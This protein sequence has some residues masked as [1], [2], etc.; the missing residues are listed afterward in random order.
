MASIVKL[1][2]TSDT[3]LEEMLENAREEMFNLRFQQA[4]SRLEDMSRI[5][6]VRREIAQIETVLNLRR[7]AVAAAL[8][9]PSV[10]EALDGKEW[11]ADARF[12][13][14]D[15]IWKVAFLDSKNKEL[16]ASAVNLN[17]KKARG[18][19]ARQAATG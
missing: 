1:N 7:Q 12:S 8:R 9:E 4:S 19:R 11:H 16:A 3:K 14:E 10:G 18:R 13:Y 17:V 5:R 15:S 6:K 2:D